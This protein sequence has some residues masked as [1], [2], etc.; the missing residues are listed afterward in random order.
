MKR[1]NM[2]SKKRVIEVF[3]A[4]ISILV[5]AYAAITILY[6]SLYTVF[7]ADDFS[8]AMSVGAFNSDFCQYVGRSFEYAGDRY[9]RWGGIY[10]SMFLQA[11]LSPL[12]NFGWMQLRVVMFL[13]VFL[14]FVSLFS[15]LWLVL[16][17]NIKD[18][19]HNK[20]LICACVICSFF[21]FKAYPEVFFWFSGATSYSMPMICLMFSIICLI[22]AERNGRK[23]RKAL[24][25]SMGVI[26]GLCSAGGYWLLQV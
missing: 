24:Y 10:F 14:F 5:I 3:V 25:L 19:L 12:N 20:L 9:L 6:A 1:I 4:A 18:N 23:K 17:I 2:I 22:A 13:N 26:G 16:K 7:Q 21:N 15:L 11:F 8:H